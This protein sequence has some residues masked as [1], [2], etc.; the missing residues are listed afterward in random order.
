MHDV[1]EVFD[2]GSFLQHHDFFEFYGLSMSFNLERAV[3]KEFQK[4]VN[5]TFLAGTL[6][7][8]FWANYAN[9]AYWYLIVDYY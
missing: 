5:E 4:F 3:L 8:S 9:Y 2:P 1:L 6:T 7:F